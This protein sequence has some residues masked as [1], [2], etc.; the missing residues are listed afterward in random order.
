MN[1]VMVPTRTEFSVQIPMSQFVALGL[2]KLWGDERCEALDKELGEIDGV[3][4]IEH[5]GHL[6]NYIYFRLDTEYDT[7]KTQK[8][9]LAVIEKHLK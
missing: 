1:L 3:D 7:P 4:N 5:N 8:K 9:I 6:G 2:E